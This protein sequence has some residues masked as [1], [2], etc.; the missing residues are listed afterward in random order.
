MVKLF[1][2]GFSREMEEIE[3]VELFTRQGVVQSAIIITDK[4][5]GKSQGYGFVT[6]DDK[7]GAERAIA[8][9]DGATL[10]CRQI[11]VELRMIKRQSPKRVGPLPRKLPQINQAM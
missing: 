6:M 4:E 9:L 11:S 8:A 2:V 5:T 1:I 10:D 3:L 7:A